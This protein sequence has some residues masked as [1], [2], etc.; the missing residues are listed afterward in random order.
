MQPFL[1]VLGRNPELSR[2][3]LLN[4][5]DEVFYEPEKS[6]FIGENLKFENPRNIPREPEQLFLDRLGG[7]IRFGKILGEFKTEEDVKNEILRFTQEKKPEGK[8]NLGV[9]AWGCGQNFLRH[10]LPET[11]NLFREK[12]DRNCRIVNTPG[13]NLDS[14]KIFGEKLLRN[15]FEFLIWKRGDSFLLA[16]TVANQ[17]LR[18][19]TLRDRE[20]DFRD[21][22]MGMLPPKLAQI[23]INVANPHLDEVVID[24]FCGSGT[25]NIEAGIMGYR[26][27]GSDIDKNRT[28]HAQKN[29]EQMA[30]KFRYDKTSGEFFACDATKL[31]SCHPEPTTPARRGGVGRLDSGSRVIATEGFLG[32]NFDYNPSVRDIEANARN[33]LSLWEKVFATLETS[34][35]RVVSFCLPAWQDGRQTVSLSEKLFAKLQKT[36]YTPRVLFGGQ[37]TF[38]YARP[39]AFVAR[40]IC[41]VEKGK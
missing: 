28:T 14:G 4:F 10:F 17:N 23:L 13:Q 5:C 32:E 40:E 15:G 31:L 26:T 38:L 20:K 30:E 36:S 1:F 19:Y 41:V 11:K 24:P 34:S 6:L 12:H 3:E 35:I 2:A 29:F 27:V 9:S 39:D 22:K 25:I 16:R 18:N 37:K 33:I 8:I 21:S 7:V